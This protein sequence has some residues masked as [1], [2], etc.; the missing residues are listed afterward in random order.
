MISFISFVFLLSFSNVL[1]DNATQTYDS[2]DTTLPN[3]M[4]QMLSS[5]SYGTDYGTLRQNLRDISTPSSLPSDVSSVVYSTEPLTTDSYESSTKG[6]ESTTVLT[7][8]ELYRNNWCK[9]M[10]R[11]PPSDQIPDSLNLEEFLEKYVIA[12]YRSLWYRTCYLPHRSFSIAS[13]IFDRGMGIANSA[14]QRV[15]STS[16]TALGSSSHVLREM[17]LRPS[18]P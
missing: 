16:N 4:T 17:L 12:E 9:A 13:I 15:V 2:M 14:V 3:S 1:S 10:L 6:S 18:N 11:S 5:E 8:Y 7:P